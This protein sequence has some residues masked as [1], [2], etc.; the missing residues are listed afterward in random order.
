VIDLTPRVVEWLVTAGESLGV[1]FR[2]R[3]PLE[4]AVA[5]LLSDFA[6]TEGGVLLVGVESSGPILGVP[7]D[8]VEGTI[9]RLSGVARSIAP[10]Q[11]QVGVV[12][13][14]GRRVVYATVGK[15]VSHQGPLKS[16]AAAIN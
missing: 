8:E 16:R 13:I 3:L 11:V 7:D 15:Q 2:L 4:D 9:S 12:E 10:S 14:E 5:Q 1:V 6:R